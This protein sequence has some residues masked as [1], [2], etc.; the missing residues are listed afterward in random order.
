MS[1]AFHLCSVSRWRRRNPLIRELSPELELAIACCRFPPGVAT[2]EAIAAIL[3]KPLN[4]PHF[5]KILRRH[6]II[7]LANFNLARSGHDVPAEMRA[8]LAAAARNYV[9]TDLI[10]AAETARLQQEF[11]RAG[12]PALFLKGAT[13]GIL[14]YGALGVK[15]SW[16]IDLLTTESSMMD[17][18]ELLQR[19]GYRLI[20]PAGLSP[21][22]LARFARFYHEAQ[23]RDDRGITVELHWRL[24]AKPVMSG[25]SA[26]SE[27]QIVRLGDREARTLRDDL[28]IVFLIGHGQEHGWSRLKWLADLNALL[29]RGGAEYIEEIHAAATGLGL[30]EEASAALLLCAQLFGLVLPHEFAKR[31]QNVPGIQRLVFVSLDCITHP[32][33][34]SELSSISHTSLALLASRFRTG[35]GWKYL[36]GEFRTIW[37]QPIVRAKYPPALDPVYHILRA[38][39]FILRLPFLLLR[40]RSALIADLRRE[41]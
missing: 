33:G 25:V 18:I 17:A 21:V 24:S 23:L 11:D 19:R 37:T 28:L 16:D 27:P 40:L 30:G 38:P 36:L 8:T 22:A 26:L 7:S 20:S 10:H 34:G 14:A 41:R 4:W 3:A 5:L 1:P 39:A 12:L 6:R 32:L 35:K 29:S 31:W 15:Q 9:A 2:S 13:T